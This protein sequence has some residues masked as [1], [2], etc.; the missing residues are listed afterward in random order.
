[1]NNKGFIS[2]TL[3]Y[4]FI[5]LFISLV[6]AIIGTYAYYH[7]VIFSTNRDITNSLNDRIEA[8]YVKITNLL[9]NSGFEEPTVPSS[10]TNLDGLEEVHYDGSKYYN[11]DPT[12]DGWTNENR[13]AYRY[14]KQTSYSGDYSLMLGNYNYSEI[15]QV[16]GQNNTY[17]DE[18]GIKDVSR[19]VSQNLN[20]FSAGT[21]YL[22]FSAKVFRNGP[23]DG[24]SII[25]ATCNGGCTTLGTTKIDISGNY[26][27]WTQVSMIFEVNADSDV[28]NLTVSLKSDNS[29]SGNFILVDEL[30]L[31]DVTQIIDAT[32][33]TLDEAK[34]YFDGSALNPDNT[35]NNR[36]KIDYFEGNISYEL[37]QNI[38]RVKIT[39]DNG[40]DVPSSS[41]TV[42]AGRNIT[43]VEPPE[44]ENYT[45]LGYFSRPNGLGTQY[46]DRLGKPNE[47]EYINKDMTLY[48]FW[49]N[50]IFYFPY[51]GQIERILLVEAGE[52]RIDA[53]GAQGGSIIVGDKTY[54]GGYGGYSVGVIDAAAMT[55][56]YIGV[57][58]QGANNNSDAT[59]V[60]ASFNGGGGATCPAGTICTGGG[61]A[62][63]VAYSDGILSSFENNYSNVIL[64][65]GGGGGAYYK[66]NSGKNGGSGGGYIGAGATTTDNGGTQSTGFGFGQ[67]E[68]GNNQS[69]SGGGLY[70]GLHSDTGI[71]TGGSGY[72]NSSTLT[73]RLMYCHNCATS[74]VENT[75]TSTTDSITGQDI[76]EY[77]PLS[78]S[79]KKGNG[80]VKVLKLDNS[81]V[82]YVEL[83]FDGNAPDAE[84]TPKSM[85]YF[86]GSRYGVLPTAIR[87]GY[88]FVGWYTEPEGGIKI[89][90][91]DTVNLESSQT[92]YAHW[93][94]GDYVVSFDANGGTVSAESKL[95][96][97][98]SLYGDLP[99]P[100]RDGYTFVG[101]YTD[102]NSGD[103]ITSTSTVSIGHDHT[104]YAHWKANNYKVTFDP[105]GGSASST[106]M[107]V[108][109]NQPYGILPTATRSQYDF[110]G[111]YTQLVGGTEV[112][113]ATIYKVA[114]DQTLYARWSNKKYTFSVTP[115]SHISSF[116][117]KVGTDALLS[118]QTSYNQSKP[119]GTEFVISNIVP[120]TGYHYSGYTKSG[121]VQEVTSGD[122][123]SVKF[124]TTEGNASVTLNSA[125]NTFTI[126]YNSGSGRGSMSSQTCTYN[127]NCYLKSNSF[128]RS[129]YTFSYWL[130]SNG[131]T[132]SNGTNVKNIL[133]TN[134]SSITLT[135]QWRRNSSSGG[136][137]SGGGGGGGGGGGYGGT[138]TI[139][140]HTTAWFGNDSKMGTQTCYVNSYCTLK[141]NKFTNQLWSF[142]GW[143]TPD[144][145]VYSDQARVYNLARSGQTI[146]LTARWY[147]PGIGYTPR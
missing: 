131:K 16:D 118:N 23:T 55:Y 95:V 106:S 5:I 61:G 10:L 122:S 62:T 52:Y 66:D 100:T 7:G 34:S 124:K 37:Y 90:E 85:W 144:N 117:I 70:G 145:K 109:Y 121:S 71:G 104:L 135:A 40:P 130:G 48:A 18:V 26:L 56:L 44:R 27:D 141:K 132:Y 63:H 41:I 129:G 133:S 6:A 49:S 72:I 125:P 4:S 79:A 94:L 75:Y 87:E 38:E 89:S 28:N 136:G 93:E 143:L 116:S 25:E 84:V 119:Y 74:N 19:V 46:F 123:S 60:R 115:D 58:Q 98:T 78:N 99:I 108:T 83:F 140:Y 29:I 80:Y 102:A 113:S 97:F 67:G 9:Q 114:G 57:G 21:H 146:T 110:I 59:T 24:T 35:T 53:W 64:V 2:S 8:Q 31:T 42:V 22:Y 14:V 137:S 33:W 103:E 69:G 139:K 127:Q 126:K 101:W 54:N 76:D 120:K 107:D 142:V 73:D 96:T 51:T 128:Y 81:L 30:L 47:D 36:Y 43:Q 32:G 65:A 92:L 111:W 39:F 20:N 112:T 3:I 77:E 82:N 105:N 68:S 50:E 91:T 45:F 11:L 86:R 138:Y 1:M 13:Y 134:G 15:Y 88:S 147:F 17:V 12:I